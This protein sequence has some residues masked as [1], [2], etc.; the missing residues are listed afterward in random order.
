Y[1]TNLTQGGDE[2]DQLRR[3]RKRG[4]VVYAHANPTYT[5]GRRFTRGLAYN[6]FVSLPVHYLLTYGVNRI[7]GRRVFGSAPA[8]R[9]ADGSFAATLAA[10][11]VAAPV[12]VLAG[13]E[14]R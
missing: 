9:Q 5:S 13:Q 2:L 1:D 12:P 14:S 6:V 8:I 10:G 4:R 3:L 7:A 11:P